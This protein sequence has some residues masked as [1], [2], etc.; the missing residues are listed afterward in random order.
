MLPSASA[1]TLGRSRVNV[2]GSPRVRPPTEVRH[3]RLRH[4][5]RPPSSRISPEVRHANVALQNSLASL[6]H[7]DRQHAPSARATPPLQQPPTALRLPPIARGKS[8]ATEIV[9]DISAMLKESAQLYAPAGRPARAVD[10]STDATAKEGDKPKKTIAKKAIVKKED[11]GSRIGSKS[12]ATLYVRSMLSELRA[13]ADK[14]QQFGAKV[15]AILEEQHRGLRTEKIKHNVQLVNLPSEAYLERERLR[16]EERYVK[17]RDHMRQVLEQRSLMD[18]ARVSN[19]AARTQFWEQ[20]RAERLRRERHEEVLRRRLA[21]GALVCLIART[22]KMGTDM[23]QM[24]ERKRQFTLK[25]A[26]AGKLAVAWRM[27]VLRRRLKALHTVR[28]CVRPLIFWWKFNFRIRKKREANAVLIEY[29]TARAEASRF[30]TRIKQYVHS[31]RK[32]QA[33]WRDAWHTLKLQINICKMWWIY[34]DEKRGLSHTA[35]VHNEQRERAE[36]RDVLRLDLRARKAEHMTRIIKWRKERR[37]YDD[38]IKE[39]LMLIEAK[40]LLTDPA[41]EES[42]APPVLDESI[43]QGR[44]PPARPIFTVFG[45]AGHF[46]MLAEKMELKKQADKR[47]AD[48][49]WAKQDALR[50]EEELTA[51]P[52]GHGAE[53]AA[54]EEIS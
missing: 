8:H 49:E 33:A 18:E 11:S 27:I 45:N 39:Q 30:Q 1:P 42:K 48:R 21:W 32:V 34:A 41:G 43:L 22:N 40:R 46:R 6:A 16:R 44:K 36:R 24:R 50:M 2:S 25:L 15:E 10:V 31:V 47:K 54:A 4:N 51:S 38:F 29:L 37:E 13:D 23:A 5:L 7:H 26:S 17:E 12:E 14:R 52:A 20:E 19:A 35:A 28:T 3:M 9:D 53:K